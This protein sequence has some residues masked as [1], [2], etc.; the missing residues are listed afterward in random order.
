[1]RLLCALATLLLQAALPPPDISGGEA[2]AISLPPPQEIWYHTGYPGGIA[3]QPGGMSALTGPIKMPAVFRAIWTQ[4][5]IPP[6]QLH[7][8]SP[9]VPGRAAAAP[10]IDLESLRAVHTDRY[11]QAILTGEPRD[12]ATSQGLPH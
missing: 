3:G 1:V 7:T 5:L 8:D 10:P 4:R 12:L 11:L 6:A 9:Q 2:P